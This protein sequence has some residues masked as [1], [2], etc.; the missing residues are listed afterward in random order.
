MTNID[1]HRNKIHGSKHS[2]HALSLVKCFLKSFGDPNI[3]VARFAF[4]VSVLRILE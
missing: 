1:W 2:L 4:F 3:P